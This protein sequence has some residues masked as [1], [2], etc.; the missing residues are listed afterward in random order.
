MSFIQGP[1]YTKNDTKLFA[2][3][4]DNFPKLWYRHKLF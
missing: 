1:P 2:E 4:L 3:Y